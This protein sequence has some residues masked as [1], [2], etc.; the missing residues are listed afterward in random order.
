[1]PNSFEGAQYF[2]ILCPHSNYNHFRSMFARAL[3]FNSTQY[4]ANCNHTS[5]DDMWEVCC[6]LWIFNAEFQTIVTSFTIMKRNKFNWWKWVG[7]RGEEMGRRWGSERED[8]NLDNKLK[9]STRSWERKCG[10]PNQCRHTYEANQ[11]FEASVCKRKSSIE[12]LRS[13]L[14]VLHY[15]VVVVCL[16]FLHC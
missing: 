9:L 11:E 10:S 13:F 8:A 15:F 1:M 5:V 2:V 4:R 3:L 16:H 7:K 12:K 14:M 6:Y